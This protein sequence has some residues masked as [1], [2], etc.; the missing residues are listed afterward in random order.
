MNSISNAGTISC[1]WGVCENYLNVGG[2]AYRIASIENN[3][4]IAEKHSKTQSWCSTGIK[5]LSYALVIPPLVAFGIRTCARYKYQF[6]WIQPVMVPSGL[7]RVEALKEFKK[8]FSSS[9]DIRRQLSPI[10]QRRFSPNDFEEERLRQVLERLKTLLPLKGDFQSPSKQRSFYIKHQKQILEIIQLAL[11]CGFHCP[12]SEGQL[13]FAKSV[14]KHMAHFLRSA[15]DLSKLAAYPA[16][17][18]PECLFGWDSTTHRTP[19]LL[20]ESIEATTGCEKRFKEKHVAIMYLLKQLRRQIKLHCK[21]EKILE[22]ID[23]MEGNR[24][25][26]KKALKYLNLTWLH[27]TKASV[28]VSASKFFEGKLIPL[29]ELKKRAVVWTGVLGNGAKA[30]GVNQVALSGVTLSAAG[31]ACQYAEGFKHAI[32][33]DERSCENFFQ[34]PPSETLINNPERFIHVIEALKRLQSSSPDWITDHREVLQQKRK[35]IEEVL[36]KFYQEKS[37]YYF[38]WHDNSYTSDFYNFL[39]ALENFDQFLDQSEDFTQTDERNRDGVDIPIVVGS[40]T[41]CGRPVNY[42]EYQDKAEE[43]F[44]GS[45]TLGRDIQ[46]IFTTD[47]PR[48][49]KIVDRCGF[50]ESLRVEPMDVLTEASSIHRELAPYFYDVYSLKKWQKLE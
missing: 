13:V 48:V 28:I 45:L 11:Q 27:G 49:Q 42:S 22:K 6:Q 5:A 16:C 43:L 14:Y 24:E 7:Q 18:S 17:L 31:I 15:T 10:H 37:V 8:K 29:G 2:P 33:L 9:I 12:A 20:I 38:N 3:E 50:G 36:D 46:V 35:E 21:R 19:A 23:P 32:D 39:I 25:I 34:C 44:E 41:I 30:T 4:I 1:L 40:S 47:V 26:R